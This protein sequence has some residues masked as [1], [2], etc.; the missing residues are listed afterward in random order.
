M[1]GVATFELGNAAATITSFPAGR[2]NDQRSPLLV[3]TIGVLFFLIAYLG[4][5]VGFTTVI[6]LALAFIA[7]GVAIG[8]IET[9][10]HAAVVTLAP[11]DVRGSAFGL[12]AGVQSF[13]NIIASGVAG[14]LWTALSGGVAFL[15]L[16]AWMV[17][18]AGCTCLAHAHS[19]PGQ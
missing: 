12:L 11:S 16:A 1:I 14:I 2:L 3:L 18:L 13:G 5:A 10:E 6:P 4:F 8:C 7:G 17:G 15:F 9:A 19:Q